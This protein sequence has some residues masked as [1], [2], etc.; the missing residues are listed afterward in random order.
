MA[1]TVV[2]HTERGGETQLGRALRDHQRVLGIA[3]ARADHR[4]DVDLELG[5]LGQVAQLA[6][7]H[8]QA[9]LGDVIRLHVVDADLQAIELGRVE[10]ADLLGHEQ[11]AVRDQRADHAALLDALDDAREV[12]MQQRLT[13]ADRDDR[14]A[15]FREL[16]DAAEHLLG[17]HRIRVIVVLVAVSAREVAA[18]HGHDVHEH[19]AIGMQHGLCDLAHFARSAEQAASSTEFLHKFRRQLRATTG[20]S[21][22]QRGQPRGKSAAASRNSA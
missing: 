2:D 14:G 22:P 18:A 1:G 16:V 11:V 9:L 10:R 3:D 19:R 6:I 21:P 20:S 8:F 12:G 17:R 5:E 15:Q 4:V 7:E 13:A